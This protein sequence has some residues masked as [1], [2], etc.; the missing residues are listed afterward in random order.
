VAYASEDWLDI[1]VVASLFRA[2]EGEA[3]PFRVIR[4]QVIGII[5]E[6]IRRGAVVGDVRRV[7]ETWEFVPWRGSMS[8]AMDR[9]GQALQSLD[10]YPRVGEI[11]RLTIDG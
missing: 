7:D 10:R 3:L 1:Q 2:P 9:I 8:A 4:D 5:G 11:G 6:L